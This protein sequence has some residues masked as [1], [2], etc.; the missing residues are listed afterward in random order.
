MEQET[1]SF[2][3]EDCRYRFRR[4]RNWNGKLCP[5]CGRSY[6]CKRDDEINKMINEII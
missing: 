5:Y 2:I 1:A 4:E 3:C 6:T